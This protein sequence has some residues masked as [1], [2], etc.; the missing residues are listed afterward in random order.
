MLVCLKA[1]TIDEAIQLVNNNQYGNGTAIFT[2]YVSIAT[3]KISLLTLVGLDQLPGSSNMKLMLVRS[4]ST[5][6]SLSPFLSSLSLVLEPLLLDPPTFT[7]RYNV[8]LVEL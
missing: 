2:Q 3:G 8:L 7:E 6:P 4:E 5:F 1:N